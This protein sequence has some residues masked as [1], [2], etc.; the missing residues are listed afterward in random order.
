M[1]RAKRNRNSGLAQ[2]QT[3]LAVA[4]LAL[5]IMLLMFT[6][7]F[8]SIVNAQDIIEG[9]RLSVSLASFQL[10]KDLWVMDWTVLDSP[11]KLDCKTIFTE[12]T[13]ESI[14]RADD[15]VQ[16]SKDGGLKEAQLKEAVMKSMRECW[17]MFGEGKV[18]VQQAVDSSGTAC[19]VCSEIT[20]NDE[21][22]KENPGLILGDMYGYAEIS[23]I[24]PQNEKTYLNYFLEAAKTRPDIKKIISENRGNIVLDNDHKQYS[25][26]FAITAQSQ[27]KGLLFGEKSTIAA[28]SGIVDCYIGNSKDGKT[29][30]VNGDDANDI[31]CDKGGKNTGLIFG[32]VI[33]GGTDVDLLNWKN[34]LTGG[35]GGGDVLRTYP[36]TVRLVPTSE[37]G[38][39]CKR[40]Y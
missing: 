25:V 18:K 31:G 3:V 35:L 24:P 8:V 13:K 26:V 19:V 12:I 11:F 38:N 21:F 16:L 30:L 9:C 32:T 33:D 2:S 34:L 28:G 15:K 5:G 1:A 27:T 6:K 40:V 36:A 20:A 7:P 22:I 39:N 10:Q 4:A 14:N 23:G 37:L 29:L 17:Y